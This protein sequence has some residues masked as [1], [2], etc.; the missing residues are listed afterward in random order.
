MTGAPVRAAKQKLRAKFS[1]GRGLDESPVFTEDLRIALVTFQCRKNEANKS[2]L[3][4]DG[5]LDWATQLALG[6]VS[7]NP[8]AG[9][10]P[11]GNPV[12]RGVILTVQ[13]TGVDMWS[14]PPADTAR[15][16][17]DV[18]YWQPV[19]NY[20]ASPFPM[21]QSYLAGIE[22]LVVQ[23]RLHAGKPKVL[24]G[25]SQGA[26]VTSRVWKHEVSRP[27]GRLYDLRDE[28]VASVTWGNPDRELG[29]A[30]GNALDGIPV[31]EGRGITDDRMVST[32]SWWL[33]FAH[34]ANSRFGRDL[35]TDTVDG[36]VGEYGTAIWKI[37]EGM[38]LTGVD[39]LLEQ[40]L[41][42]VERPLVEVVS[43]FQE[44]THAGAFF[45]S[46]TGPHVNYDV[47]SA[48]RFLRDVSL[49]LA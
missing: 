16:L 5:V 19:G 9:R 48:V 12:R 6:V 10:F 39:G 43:M 37:V 28:F 11:F 13:G 31:P 49:K 15:A 8:P 4:T 17:Q 27:G 42:I 18:F 30:H 2:A 47:S 3:R 22:E 38:K 23:C 25:Y 46:G 35:Y 44:I 40:V 36:D 33:D 26:I 45:F 34:G 29:V 1:Y 20:P 41:E 32:P 7:P 24:A 21:R 14:G